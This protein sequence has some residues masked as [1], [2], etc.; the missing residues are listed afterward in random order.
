MVQQ[1]KVS[2]RARSAG[3]VVMTTSTL[4]ALAVLGI[5]LWEDPH[6]DWEPRSG[7]LFGIDVLYDPSAP[8]LGLIV[9]SAVIACLAAAAVVIHESRVAA[10]H[11]RT[12][13][14]VL[15]RPLAPRRI[16]EATRGEFAGEVTVTALIPAHNEA[17][18]LAATL[19]SLRQQ[20]AAPDRII[21][22]ADNCTD[23]TVPIA[24]AAGVEVFETQDNVHKKGGG[25]NQ[26]LAGIL[27]TLGTNDTLLIMDADTRFADTRFLATARQRF[28]SDRALMAVGGLFRGEPGNGLLGQFQRNE[29]ARYSR[30]IKRRRGRVFV[31]TGTAS[32]FR[33]TALREVA[34]SRGGLLPGHPGE[35]YDTVALTEDN[36][37]T[38]AIKTLGGLTTSPNECGVVT[39]IMPTWRALWN[40]RLRWQRGALENLGQYGLTS[41]TARYW[42]QQIGISYSVIAL[43]AYFVLI[44]IMMLALTEWIWFTFWV[45]VGIIFMLERVITVWS[46]GWKARLLAVFVIPELLYDLYCNIIFVKGVLDMTFAKE[47]TWSHHEQESPRNR[48][49]GGQ[50]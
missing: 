36:E 37:I 24:R 31:L 28:T 39:E 40:Q 8:T 2:R 13:P 14:E 21:V 7:S 5:I 18:N 29:F 4:L 19:E 3:V 44:I 16:M 12:A 33:A 9:L 48:V 15:K 35:V 43:S 42:S 1:S 41:T 22:V 11:R 27:P 6:P 17:Q 45:T 46:G 25:L 47:A 10:R 50:A 34:A 26:A 38:L 30:E 32:V 23:E 49:A 20:T